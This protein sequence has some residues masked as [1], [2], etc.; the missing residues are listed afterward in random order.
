M[1]SDADGDPAAD[2]LEGSE[3]RLSPR[4]EAL[5]GREG[6]NLKVELAPHTLEWALAKES[7]VNV[8]MMLDALALVKP[9]VTERLRG[10]LEGADSETSAEA[11]LEAVK[12]VKGRFAQE[13]ADLLD[14]DPREFVVPEFLREALRWVTEEPALEP[15]GGEA[16]G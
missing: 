14:E 10:E 7:E 6:D 9:R 2:E 5:R 1:I 11:L 12:D 13:L 15:E 4:A 8:E 16:D 3:P